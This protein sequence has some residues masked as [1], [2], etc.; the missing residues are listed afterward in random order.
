MTVF[1]K[2]HSVKVAVCLLCSSLQRLW[3][4]GVYSI[5]YQLCCLV[6]ALKM[7]QSIK[8]E[9]NRSIISTLQQYGEYH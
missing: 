2:L 9:P 8:K 6:L 7:V 1:R 3:S 5:K 4:T